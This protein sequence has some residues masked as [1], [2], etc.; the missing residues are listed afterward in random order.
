MKNRSVTRFFSIA[1]VAACF[2]GAAQA[3]TE[4]AAPFGI[5]IGG[6]C[7]DALTKM[8]PTVLSDAFGDAIHTAKNPGALFPGASEV[9]IRCEGED[10]LA[11]QFSAPKGFGN[12]EAR[13]VY[14][15]LSKLY[16]RVEGSQIP[17]V[18]SG[19]A[20]F[21]KGSNVIEIGAPHLNP[22]FTVVYYTKRFYDGL[23]E[24]AKKKAKATSTSKANL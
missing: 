1:I 15:T 17:E 8:G 9:F 24:F 16:K 11:L 5:E 10:V 7:K 3:K 14:L 2:A 12:P 19:Y 13:S 6:S 4:N 21:V 20:R 18:G 23:T 22:N